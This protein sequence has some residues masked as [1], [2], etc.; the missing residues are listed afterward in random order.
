MSRAAQMWS[1]DLIVSLVIFSVALLLTYTMAGN[2]FGASDYE[3]VRDE[4]AIAASLLSGT[5][6]PQ[7]WSSQ[8]VIRAG[9]VAD[10]RLSLRKAHELGSLSAQQARTRLRITDS[11]SVQLLNESDGVVPAFGRCSI[12]DSLPSTLPHN[13]S[14]PSLALSLSAGGVSQLVANGTNMTVYR[15]ES[16]YDRMHAA[17]VILLEGNISGNTTPDEAVLALAEQARRGI[18]IIIVG[19]PTVGLLGAQ[20]TV[21]NATT[22][23]VQGA[24]GAPLGLGVNE[25]LNV[26]ADDSPRAI[27]V[28]AVPSG[29]EVGNYEEIA[30]LPSGEI[31]YATWTYGDA[32]VWYL[33]T[34]DG[35]RQNGTNLTVSLAGAMRSMIVVS[36]PDCALAQAPQD[37]RQV[38]HYDR[39][40]M[41][42]DAPLT[43]R[44]I[45]WR[46]R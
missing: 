3:D 22:L 43:M 20:P 42:H 8:S 39:R 46:Q 5:G 38:A 45:V 18:T 12:G 29:Q 4:A 27:G 40:I 44:T 14:L 34:A 31:A 15:N 26:S 13:A 30:R 35:L 6:Y 25:T 16:A 11:F 23:L 21:M 36:W 24:A 2:V 9:I 17:D 7:H 1:L 28:I 10:D 33:A 37:A 32:R 41:H 19:N